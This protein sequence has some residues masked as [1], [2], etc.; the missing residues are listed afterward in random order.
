METPCRSNSGRNFHTGCVHGSDGDSD[1][2]SDGEKKRKDTYLGLSRD[3]SICHQDPHQKTLGNDCA[4]CHD[5][6]GAK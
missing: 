2:D 4:K 6:R 3:C 1:G 5:S